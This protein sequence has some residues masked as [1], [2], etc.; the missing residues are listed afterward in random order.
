MAKSTNAELDQF[1]HL[2]GH[3][4]HYPA[5]GANVFGSLRL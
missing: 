5:L 3:D 2:R 4:V 1:G